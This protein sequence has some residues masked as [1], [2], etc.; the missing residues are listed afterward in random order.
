MD[1]AMEGAAKKKE[2]LMRDRLETLSG[3]LRSKRGLPPAQKGL[4]EFNNIS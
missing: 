2:Q 4:Y 1:E 3:I